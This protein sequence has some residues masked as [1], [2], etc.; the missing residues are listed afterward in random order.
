MEQADA[1][2]PPNAAALRMILLASA[3]PFIGKR[4]H[5]LLQFGKGELS[6]GLTVLV[7]GYQMQ[8]IVLCN[9]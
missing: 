7:H 9:S 4:A 3:I 5:R 8:A 2:T 6:W 1:R